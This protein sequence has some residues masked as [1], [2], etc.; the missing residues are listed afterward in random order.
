MVEPD[1][2]PPDWWRWWHWTDAR[3]FAEAMGVEAV[4]LVLAEEGRRRAAAQAV[5]DRW[6]GTRR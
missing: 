4:E 1:E 6:A 5:A 3:A 2:V